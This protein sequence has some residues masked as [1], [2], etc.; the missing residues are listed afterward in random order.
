MSTERWTSFSYILIN[1]KT[2]V[3]W[4]LWNQLI[5]YLHILCSVC[6]QE[7]I[8]IY[9]PVLLRYLMV[10]VHLLNVK[11]DFLFQIIMT[12][13]YFHLTSSDVSLGEWSDEPDENGEK[14]RFI[15][16]TLSINYS[17][18]PKC[19]PSTETQVTYSLW[20]K[21][22]DFNTEFLEILSMGHVICWCFIFI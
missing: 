6:V 21:F 4:K 13:A 5:T 3:W 14:T 20:N 8:Y 18:G 9:V 12:H 17:L 22:D 7:L 2:F 1:S 19:S 10:N 11:W 15:S 16:Y